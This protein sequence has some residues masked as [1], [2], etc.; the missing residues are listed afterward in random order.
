[1]LEAYVKLAGEKKL[2]IHMPHDD[3]FTTATMK[4][5]GVSSKRVVVTFEPSKAENQAGSIVAIT[6][7]GTKSSESG[8]RD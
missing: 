1:M 2:E 5:M 7:S 3:A 4:K 8:P 6:P